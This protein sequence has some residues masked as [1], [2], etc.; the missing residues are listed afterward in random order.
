MTRRPVW[1][2]SRGAVTCII[3]GTTYL[4]IRVA[5]E[6]VPPMLMGGIRWTIAALLLAAI[7]Y[8]RGERLP[9]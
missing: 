7:V 9:A 2:T 4:A 6:A 3:W 8:A 5:L 1:P